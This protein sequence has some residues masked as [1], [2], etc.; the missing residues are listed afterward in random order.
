MPSV[1]LLLIGGGIAFY[2]LWQLRRW[3][4]EA[5]RQSAAGPRRLE[6]IV[7]ELIATAEGASAAVAEKTEALELSITKANAALAKL[8]AANAGGV[9]SA[10]PRRLVGPRV[11]RAA[12]PEPVAAPAAQA[13]PVLMSAPDVPELHRRVYTLADTGQDVTTIARQLSLTKGEVQFILGL[14]RM[15]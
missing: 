11:K 9:Q 10:A 8:D 7:E 3:L 4:A 14:R 6:A 12:A 13:D 5:E 15:N 1:L 2:S